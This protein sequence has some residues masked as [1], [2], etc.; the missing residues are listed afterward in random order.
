MVTWL[1]L[2]GKRRFIMRGKNA[3][4]LNT[5]RYILRTFVIAFGMFAIVLLSG[6][7][8][9]GGEDTSNSEKIINNLENDIKNKIS[10]MFPDEESLI[11]DSALNDAS[12]DANYEEKLEELNASIDNF[13][14][15]ITAHQEEQQNI[16]FLMVRD[17]EK[18]NFIYNNYSDTKSLMID[19]F[20]N[21]NNENGKRAFLNA[22]M[23]YRREVLGGEGGSLNATYIIGASA[24]IPSGLGIGVAY[25][26]L[27]FSHYNYDTLFC[28]GGAGVAVGVGASASG[29]L[30]AI[31]SEGWIFGFQKDEQYSGGPSIGAG[32]SIGSSLKIFAGL[33]ISGGVSSSR[34]LEGSCSISG[35]NPLAP[36]GQSTDKYGFSYAVKATASVGAAVG[37]TGNLTL[38]GTYSCNDSPLEIT[39]FLNDNNPSKLDTLIAGFKIAESI[40]F[41]NGGVP[42][43]SPFEL[44]AAYVA[45]LYGYL[46]DE[47]LIGYNG[48]DLSV[49]KNEL[50]LNQSSPSEQVQI[51]NIGG[52]TL[53]WEAY[54][55]DPMVTVAPS[56]GTGDG[57]LTITATNFS[58]IY[59]STV[60][61]EKT[62]DSSDY[63]QIT[64]NVT[65]T[66]E[67][68]PP[69]ISSL[70][71]DPTSVE[72][73]GTSTITCS[74]SDIDG[75]VLA[76]SWNATGGSIN[77]SSSTVTYTAPSTD[78]I[79]TITCTVDDGNSGTDSDTVTIT[80]GAHETG[81][82]TDI[83]D[84][85]VYRTV[86]IGD[87]WWFAENLNFITS[88]SWAYD[89]NL[90]N[91]EIYGRLYNWATANTAYPEGWH[92]PSDNEWKI[93]EMY[94]GMSEEIANQTG[95]R[96]DNVG[97][98]LK[99]GGSSGFE[100]LFGGY[101]YPYTN[102]FGGKG[103]E[104]TFWLSD[105]VG[106]STWH[107]RLSN[108]ETGVFRSFTFNSVK[109]DAF[110][111]RPIKD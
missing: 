71:A 70:T 111:V 60:T 3:R 43:G 108:N 25:D 66:P 20:G 64:V 38:S 30:S 6:C 39:D 110:S 92:L 63:E 80:I 87:Q 91:S 10:D 15:A 102:K 100:V 17:S 61:V 16:I 75:D 99:E 105:N 47:N 36:S 83:R 96:G 73:D 98:G 27:N 40:I 93:L 82:F 33:G 106:F 68:T 69:E 11:L 49:N 86:K 42:T 48:P 65:Y 8:G 95:W 14:D 97:T 21:I 7:G 79:Y 1:F 103:S 85:R 31:V 32:V 46:Y 2:F 12:D 62:D 88:G 22:G 77:G 28:S 76:Y 89:N 67:N 84:G 107:R 101:Y 5:L 41:S 26:F 19:I 37:A 13:K 59:F 51:T 54:S 104:A 18:R 45:V 72:P 34:S 4:N 109:V 74:T 53:T 78:G 24:S 55:D 81:T 23:G 90:N 50:N 29:E 57:T 9:G 35:C 94:L 56:S 58:T 44:L 52:G